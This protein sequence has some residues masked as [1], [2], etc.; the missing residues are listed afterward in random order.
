MAERD[1]IQQ[2]DDAVEAMFAGRVVD[3]GPE[4]TSLARIGGWLRELPAEDFRASLA[5]EIGA[6]IRDLE[7]EK[8]TMS[9][10][11]STGVRAGYPALLPYLHVKSAA[12]QI[13]FLKSVFGGEEILRFAT[14]DGSKIMHAEVRIGDSVIEMGEPEQV[15]PMALHVYVPDVDAAYERALHTGANSLG[16]PTDHPYGE[17]G[18]SVRDAEGNFWYLATAKGAHYVAKGLHAVNIYLHPKGAP[19]FIDF[20][21]SAFGAEEISRH[22]AG[23]AVV[24]AEMRLGDSVLEMGEAHGPYQQMPSM[25]HYYVA[26]ADEAYRRAIAAGAVSVRTP[27]DQPYGERNAAVKDAWGN[28]WFV[29]TA[30]SA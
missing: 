5:R 12:G 20:L 27:A 10:A 16:E 15:Q 28:T 7:K 3:V 22:E 30:K 23:G 11:T 26:D 18:A 4:A 17:R 24:H 14:P 13:D 29:A 2:L 1:L 21:K 6:A 9:T 19:V 8:R 25:I